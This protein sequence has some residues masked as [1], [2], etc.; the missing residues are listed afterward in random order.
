MATHVKRQEGQPIVSYHFR[1]NKHCKIA[2]EETSSSHKDEDGVDNISCKEDTSGHSRQFLLCRG[3]WK[4]MRGTH[5][6]MSHLDSEQEEADTKLL[7]YD[8]EAM[9]DFTF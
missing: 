8:L 6:D 4:P 9:G 7:L 3:I 5:C 2:P 1:Y